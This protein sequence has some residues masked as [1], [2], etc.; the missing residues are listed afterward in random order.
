MSSL[1][2]PFSGALHIYSPIG[3][4]KIKSTFPSFPSDISLKLCLLL[5][6]WNT[7]S[8]PKKDWG[9]RGGVGQGLGGMQEFFLVFFSPSSSFFPHLFCICLYIC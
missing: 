4:H 2:D 5:C 1:K 3:L 8:P 7:L 6:L 9:I